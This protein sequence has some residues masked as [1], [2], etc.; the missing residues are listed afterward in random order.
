MRKRFEQ[1]MELGVKPIA[2]TP[3]RLKSRDDIPALIQSLVL[4]YTTPSYNEKIFAILEQVI[5]KGKKPTGR[6]GMDLW[7]IF[8]LAQ[9]RLALGIDYDRLDE[10][11]SS[12]SGLRQLLGIENNADFSSDNFIDF[13]YDRIVDNLRLLDDHSL[14]QINDVIVAF[15]HSKV[16]KKKEAAALFV[17]SDSYVVES[18]VHFP[19]D[20]NLL[21]D[22]ARKALD[23]IEKIKERCPNLSSW[24]KAKDW[25]RELKNGC[26]ALGKACA[27]GGKN[28][29]QRVQRTTGDYLN[30]AR[31][32]SKK[33]HTT[34]VPLVADDMPTLILGLEL[35]RFTELLDKHIDLVDRRLLQQE[36]IPHGEKMFS[37]FEQYTEWINKGKSRPNVELGKKVSITTDQYG[38]II[39][40]RVM[41]NEADSQIVMQTAEELL[42]K[43]KIQNWSF[44]K[45]YYHKDN[46]DYLKKKVNQVIMPKKGKRTKAE[47]IEETTASYKTLKNKHSAVESN[48]NELEHCGLNRC[49]DKGY[50]AFKRYISI[51]ITAY[52]LKRIGR[53]LIQQERKRLKKQ[54]KSV[55]KTAA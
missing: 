5:V 35:E 37:I 16:F 51:G 22:C 26:R 18:N 53:E 45:G 14:Q 28:K 44:D 8:V 4:I 54:K 2:E 50:E 52:N 29:E 15:G 10:L 55:Y 13:G 3:V 33:L 19:T 34:S 48:I 49:P 24:R 1:Q 43:Y 21:W 39:D 6:P 23:T 41:E 47:T 32:L 46:K 25:K 20:Y 9:F 31:V 11:V 42:P 30:K 17:K 36:Q 12:H 7:Q 27:C 38:M 40:H